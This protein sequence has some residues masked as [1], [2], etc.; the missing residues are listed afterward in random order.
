MDPNPDFEWTTWK[1]KNLDDQFESSWIIY[2][3][4][5]S[6]TTEDALFQQT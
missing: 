5:K 2:E 1:V 6:L 4:G 3:Y